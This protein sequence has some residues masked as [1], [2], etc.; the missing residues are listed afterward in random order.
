MES[1]VCTAVS[2]LEATASERLFSLLPHMHWM[3]QGRGDEEEK[4]ATVSM[5][6]RLEADGKERKGGNAR[7]K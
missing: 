1:R 4:G 5:K 2:L 6:E 7:G 3:R